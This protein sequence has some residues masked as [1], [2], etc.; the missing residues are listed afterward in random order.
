MKRKIKFQAWDRKLSVII[1]HE[2]LS[3]HKDYMNYGT[4]ATLDGF[5][6]HPDRDLMEFVA[7]DR[8]NKEIYTDYI[9]ESKKENSIGLVSFRHGGFGVEIMGNPKEWIGIN[10]IIFSDLDFEIIGNIHKTPELLKN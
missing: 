2:E 6:Q 1:P 9:L 4:T 7:Y 5:L 3:C 8:N 10:S